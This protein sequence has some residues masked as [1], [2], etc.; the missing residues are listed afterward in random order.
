[1]IFSIRERLANHVV[2]SERRVY[3]FYVR[4]ECKSLLALSQ[5]E[6]SPSHLLLQVRTFAHNYMVPVVRSG[7]KFCLS[8]RGS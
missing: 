7:R 4:P 8:V 2:C 3:L 5:S 6:A 1:M